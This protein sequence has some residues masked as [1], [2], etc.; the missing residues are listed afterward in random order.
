MFHCLFVSSILKPSNSQE[1]C[2][3][4]PMFSSNLLSTSSKQI[5]LNNASSMMFAFSWNTVEGV[6][7]VLNK[8]KPDKL[9]FV[10]P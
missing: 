4:L 10:I 2:K 3:L 9:N 1:L 6:C 8:T 5:T 7:E